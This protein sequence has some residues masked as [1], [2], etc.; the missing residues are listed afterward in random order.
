MANILLT[1]KC[2]RSCPYCF[3][4]EY[5]KESEQSMLS[6]EDLIYIIDL[7]QIS[8]E[9]NVSFLGGEPTLHPL[10]FQA[11]VFSNHSFQRS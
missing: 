7:L 10:F 1:E 5:M 9:K 8:D 4:K 3:A 11:L 6:W 2:V